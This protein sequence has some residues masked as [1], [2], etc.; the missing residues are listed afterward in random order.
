PSWGINTGVKGK[1]SS[2]FI[3]FSTDT[4]INITISLTLCNRS[5]KI[6]IRMQHFRGIGSLLALLL[7]TIAV[8]QSAD[9]YSNN[10][11]PSTTE[12]HSKYVDGDSGL[13]GPG[14]HTGGH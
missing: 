7:V 6:I 13:N 14:H 12:I 8:V 11:I 4:L 9:V 3:T 2:T 1:P 10:H 5:T